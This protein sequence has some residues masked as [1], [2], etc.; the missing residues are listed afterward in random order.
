MNYPSINL[1]AFLVIVPSIAF[2]SSTPTTIFKDAA[3]LANVTISGTGTNAAVS[4]VNG[5][6]TPATTL[7]ADAL[8]VS[9]TS[10]TLLPTI[11]HQTS[12]ALADALKISF[13][14]NVVSLGSN[15]VFRMGPTASALGGLS[16][17]TFGIQLAS[18]G[19]VVAEQG[20]T[21][22]SGTNA[23]VTYSSAFQ[24]NTRFNVTIFFNNSA[25]TLDL[26]AYSG[27]AALA[28]NQWALY[29]GGTLKSDA[30]NERYDQTFG[31]NFGFIWRAGTAASGANQ[32]FQLDNIEFTNI[33][34]IPEP[35]SAAALCGL[36]VLGF[37]ALRRRDHRG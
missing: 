14:M 4:V 8:R 5:S 15:I 24:L 7:D 34:A 9:D 22:G 28:A 19:S 2:A 12:V 17:S 20:L 1:A 13:D 36:G 31:E 35:S 32:N 26:T 18:T 30:L 37:A 23:N 27:P 11:N 25:S 33:S 29:V 21:V 3:N 10:S 6:T 16:S